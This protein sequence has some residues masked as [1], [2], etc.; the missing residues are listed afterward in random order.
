MKDEAFE[1]LLKAWG[2]YYHERPPMER[3]TRQRVSHPIAQS[4]Q[5]APG[6]RVR[7]A[8]AKLVGRDG[9]DRRSIMGAAA[10]IAGPVPMA[11]VDPVR[12]K[13]TNSGGYGAHDSRPV[14]RELQQVDQAVRELE[15]ISV[16]RAMC[17]RVQYCTEGDHASKVV[18]VNDRM[19]ACTRHFD[20]IGLSRY[21][22]ELLYARTWL[23][24]R[25]S[26]A[27]QTA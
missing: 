18:V 11:Y 21:R 10:G 25:L 2:L 1:T 12:C 20:R 26:P 6:K 3:G 4:M 24:G 22:D 19:I 8:T 27:L 16:V 17:I 15:T 14:P 13:Q 23:H 9:R 5:F 7:H